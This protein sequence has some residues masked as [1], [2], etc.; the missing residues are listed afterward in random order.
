LKS[1]KILALCF[2][3]NGHLLKINKG[4]F[5]ILSSLVEISDTHSMNSL[6]EIVSLEE[7]LSKERGQWRVR[8]HTV[9]Q[10]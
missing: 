8:E 5:A 10:N 1:S 4:G 2:A 9:Q 3:A 7:I 6:W